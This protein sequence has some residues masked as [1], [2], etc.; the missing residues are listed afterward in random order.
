MGFVHGT[1]GLISAD[2]DIG[3]GLLKPLDLKK[4]NVL[5]LGSYFCA[6][7]DAIK[8]IP[9][10]ENVQELMQRIRQLLWLAPAVAKSEHREILAQ[11][12]SPSSCSERLAELLS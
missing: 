7:M 4:W 6:K 11:S 5:I 10:R 8:D 2:V 9:A 3:V 12:I 1:G